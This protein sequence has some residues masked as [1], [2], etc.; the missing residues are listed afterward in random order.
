MFESLANYSLAK[1]QVRENNSRYI[2][3]LP[4]GHIDDSVRVFSKNEIIVQ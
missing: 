1:A 4:Q 3:K 2:I